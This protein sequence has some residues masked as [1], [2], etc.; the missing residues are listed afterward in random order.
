MATFNGEKYIREQLDSIA[1]Q[2]LLPLELVIT[3]DGSTDATLGI[4]EDFARTAGF[5]VRVFRNHKRLGYADNFFKAASLCEGDLIAF[6]D[7]DDIWMEEK[8]LVCSE[9]FQDPEVMLAAHSAETVTPSGE[10]G[11]AFPDFGRTRGLG[12]ESVDPFVYPY[13]FVIVARRE[14]LKITPGADRP[15]KLFAHDQWFWLM[16]TSVGKVATIA[17]RLTLY[18]Q[19]GGNLYGAPK[20]LTLLERARKVAGTVYIVNFDQFANEMLACSQL[21][22]NIAE[23]H[24][25]WESRLR[26][27]AHR[28]E[29]RSR[30]HRMR[31][32]LYNRDSGF[33]SRVIIFA[34]LSLLGAY[35]ADH[36]GTRLGPR[37]AIK[38]LLLGVSG[39]YR[40]FAPGGDC[41]EQR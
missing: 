36:S 40:L 16:G 10:R 35:L 26:R 11:R 6:C 4:V 34:H 28:I 37:R 15:S 17:D 38:D 30:F 24:P 29:Q 3:D 33:W 32:R 14:L 1:A 20:A 13:G 19:H 31:S 2:T 22:A 23:R 5:P 27:V 39:S 12:S 41:V 9:F 18:R 25:E 7:Q 8:L 21:L